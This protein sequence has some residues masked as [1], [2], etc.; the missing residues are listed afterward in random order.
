MD[1]CSTC[2]NGDSC[3]ECDEGFQ[4]DGSNCAEICGDGKKFILP[5]DDGNVNDDDGCSST[6]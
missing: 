2:K 4:V 6:C 1:Y 3:E 5:C